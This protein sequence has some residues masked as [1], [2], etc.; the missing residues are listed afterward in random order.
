MKT[1]EKTIENIGDPKFYSQKGIAIATFFGAPLADSVLIRKKFIELD[2]ERK[3]NLTL[4]LGVLSTIA[5]FFGIFSVPDYII[6]KIPNQVIPLAYTGLIY[7][8]VDKIQ[9]KEFKVYENLGNK[10]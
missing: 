8:L 6:S 9:G 4:L 7:L 10:S 1:E 2:E 3:G 5:I